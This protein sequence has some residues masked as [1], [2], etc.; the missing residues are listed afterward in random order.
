MQLRAERL[1]AHLSEQCLPLYLVSGDELLLVQECC[2]LIRRRARQAGCDERR[3]LDAGAGGFDWK[4]LLH[5]ATEM[6]LFAD[7][8][9]IELRLPGGKPGTDG[10]KALCEYVEHSAGEDILL[11]VAGRIERQSQN[12]KWYKALDS[13]GAIVQVWPVRERELPGWLRTASR[14]GRA[15]YRTGGLQLLCERVEGNL[16]A[17]VQEVEKL[18]LLASDA[19]V[20]VDT[21]TASVSDNARYSVFGLADSA[22]KGDAAASAAHA[23]RPARRR[24]RTAGGAVGAG[25]GNPHPVRRAARLRLGPEQ[26]ARPR[27]AQGVEKSPAAPAGGPRPARQRVPGPASRAGRC[28]V[29]GSVKGYADGRPWD[30]LETLVTSPLWPD[31]SR[32]VHCGASSTGRFRTARRCPGKVTASPLQSVTLMATRVSTCACFTPSRILY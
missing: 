18:K 2:D 12:S 24:H 32:Q 15:G 3:I 13:A 26:A 29:D 21:V 27:R 14:G 10:S 8:R 25:A 6:S 4:E 16:L 22:L 19:Q 1:G 23:A 7:R 30:E 5:C 20:T 9:L 11:I 28:R 31:R 17:A